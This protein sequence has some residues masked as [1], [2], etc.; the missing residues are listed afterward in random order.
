MGHCSPKAIGAPGTLMV[1]SPE[2][3][4]ASPAPLITIAPRFIAVPELKMILLLEMFLGPLFVWWGVHETPPPATL[5]GGGLLFFVLVAHAALG[6]MSGRSRSGASP[7]SDRKSQVST[8]DS[9]L[10]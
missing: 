8:F 9:I 5:I 2:I 10:N 3:S 1:I 6:L 4:P 7:A